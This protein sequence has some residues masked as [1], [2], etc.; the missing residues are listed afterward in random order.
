METSGVAG[1]AGQTAMQVPAVADGGARRVAAG[2]F[3]EYERHDAMG[4]AA[5]VAAGEVTPGELL[6]EALARIAARN[7]ALNA[8]VVPLQEHARAAAAAP[9]PEGPFRG[10]PFLVKD[11]LATIAGVPTGSGNRL[12]ARLPW[13]HDSELVRRFRSAGLVLAGKTNTPEFG[14]TPFTEPELFGPTRNPWDPARSPGGSSGGSAAAVAARIVPMASGG[15]GGGSIRIPA[16]C[17]GLFGLKPSRGLTPTG[18]DLGEVWRGFACEHVLTR[19]VRDSAAM[20]DATAGADPG[21]PYAAPHSARP[22]LHEV[23]TP[24]GRLRIA[25]T[26]RPLFGAPGAPVHPD[27]REGLADAVALLSE[28]GHEVVEAAP[29][30]DGEAC[31]VAFVTI[32]AAETRAAIE[33]AAQLAGRK[34]SAAD[35]EA[36]TYSLGLL[37]RAMP[38][39][40][41]ASSSNTL[42]SA[43]RAVGGFFE[44]FDVL[45]TPTLARPPIM[46]GELQPRGAE[47]A[48]MR[49]INAAGAGWLLR[50]LGVVGPIAAKTFEYMPFTPLFNVT[51]QPAMS[52]PLHWN[53]QGLPIGMQF[54]GRLGDEATLLRLAGQLERARPWFDRAPPSLRPA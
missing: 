24:P 7:P 15:D 45:L 8:V 28:L 2:G 39:S 31:S 11:L 16:A 50:A 42:A 40:Q 23:S 30:I 47:R 1:S 21:A 38:A 3:D 53:A 5:L 25:F 26:A 13:P 29:G 52:V 37:G 6:E 10:V 46:I 43:T 41:Y 51:G 14:L 48:L 4:L 34:P 17:C 22:Y 19:S 54:V 12:L 33:L 27:C 35:F 49:V 18:P 32:L 20:L 36:A 44:Q 9:L